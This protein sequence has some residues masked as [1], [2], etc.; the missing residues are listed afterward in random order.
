VKPLLAL[1]GV[2]IAA[3]V[4]GC[5]APAIPE[6]QRYPAGTPLVARYVTVDGTRIRYV[7]AGQGPA[8]ILIHGLAASLFSWRHTM[9]PLARAGYRVIAYD[10]RGFGFSEKPARGY[11]NRDYVMLLLSLLDSLKVDEAILVGHSMG[12]AIA[13]EAALARPERVR[14]LVMVDAAGMGVRWPFMLR[15]ARWPVVSAL[16]EQFRGRGATARIL[17]AL[18]ADPSRVTEQEIDQ[19]YAPVAEPGFERSLR[20]VLAAYRFDA[21]RGRL[22]SIETPTLVMWGAK[23]RVIPATV[24]RQMVAHLQL[25]AFVQF[26]NAGHDLPEELPGEFNRTLLAFLAGGIPVPPG[27]VAGTLPAGLE[28]AN[29]SRYFANHPVEQRVQWDPTSPIAMH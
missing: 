18:Y 13:A 27:N 29:S 17:K 10:N 20:G 15:V 1:L 3:M 2:L 22:D 6:S 5:R 11:T 21:L 19:Y 16:F 4:S 12:G 26:P 23:D 7:E 9:L 25:G 24:G 28:S 8:V 14:A